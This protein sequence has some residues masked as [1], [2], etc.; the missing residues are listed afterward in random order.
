MAFLKIGIALSTLLAALL[1]VDVHAQSFEY[2][3]RAAFLSRFT[4]FIVWPQEAFPSRSAPIRICVYGADPFG[5]MLD[6]TLEGQSV[7]GRPLIPVR[8]MS[9]EDLSNCHVA[10]INQPQQE[11]MTTALNTLRGKPVL[12]VAD[13]EDFLDRG[14]AVRFVTVGGRLSFDVNVSAAQE[15][16]LQLS[17]KLL[18][19]ARNVKR[20]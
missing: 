20:R 2:E 18:R 4:E 12:T 3:I 6:R 1:A 9:M 16:R 14:G 17:S 19:L 13:A 11:R 7:N 10:F 8:V 15:G 5:P